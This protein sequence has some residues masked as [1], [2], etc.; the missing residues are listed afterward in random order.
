M[1]NYVFAALLFL[2]L[3]GCGGGEVGKTRVKLEDV[4]PPAM[5]TAKEKFPGINFHEAYRK[6]DGTYE[7]RGKESTGK[8]RE[9]EVKADGTF[10]AIE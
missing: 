3:A 7:I 5:Q 4:P 10:V 6:R 8:V 1:H 2:A 9:V